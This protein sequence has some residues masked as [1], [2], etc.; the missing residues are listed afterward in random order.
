MTLKACLCEPSYD[1]WGHLIKLRGNI[2]I[3]NPWWGTPTPYL[4]LC[5]TNHR[6][7]A[8]SAARSCRWSLLHQINVRATGT[9]LTLQ[10]MGV[11][12]AAGIR[13]ITFDHNSKLHREAEQRNNITLAHEKLGK[14]WKHCREEMKSST[15]ERIREWETH[16]CYEDYIAKLSNNLERGQLRPPCRAR[17]GL[18]G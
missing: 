5:T 1:C 6:E 14:L 3:L 2:E 17:S 12:R 10:Q 8:P 18:G 16:H 7:L 11:F 9:R 15:R 4:D 13:R